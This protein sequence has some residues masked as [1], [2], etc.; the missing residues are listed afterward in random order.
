MHDQK[1]GIG[2][3]C[4]HVGGRCIRCRFP[5]RAIPVEY[6]TNMIS[7]QAMLTNVWWELECWEC[8]E[9][10]SKRSV[11][12]LAHTSVILYCEF[13]KHGSSLLLNASVNF[14]WTCVRNCDSVIVMS[15]IKW[16]EKR[17]EMKLNKTN[18]NEMKRDIQRETKWEMKCEMKWEMN[19]IRT[20]TNK[21]TTWKCMYIHTNI[22][23]KIST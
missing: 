6:I 21:Y 20:N 14:G 1:T 5:S 17:N 4:R 13:Y 11:A 3:K 19:E 10:R 8:S 15:K 22:D 12:L 16:N 23:S 2:M 9:H 7:A 18:W